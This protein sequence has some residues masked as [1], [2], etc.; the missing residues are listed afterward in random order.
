M[1]LHKSLKVKDAL[2]RERNVWS[3]YER[4]LVLEKDKR[5]KDGDSVFGLPKVRTRY[6][7]RK[8]KSKKEEEKSEKE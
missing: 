8:K 3:R 4:L 7:A 6:K 5:W 2:K 1:S